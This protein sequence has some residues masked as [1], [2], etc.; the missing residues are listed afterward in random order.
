MT[1]Q[2]E[3]KAVDKVTDKTVDKVHVKK[4]RTGYAA[5]VCTIERTFDSYKGYGR[6][7]VEAHHNALYAITRRRN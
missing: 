7:P 4:H 1:N 5:W 6:T 2:L 3:N